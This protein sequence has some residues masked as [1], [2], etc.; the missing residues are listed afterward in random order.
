LD[1]NHVVIPSLLA[2][3]TVEQYPVRTRK[4]TAASM[5]LESIEPR[6][7]S[8]D[9][10]CSA[11]K[12]AASGRFGVQVRDPTAEAGLSDPCRYKALRPEGQTLRAPFY[13]KEKTSRKKRGHG[14]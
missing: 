9:E 13:E 8:K 5:I 12:Q 1:E 14:P 7:R 10:P 6:E 3:S 2:V 4:R 11:V